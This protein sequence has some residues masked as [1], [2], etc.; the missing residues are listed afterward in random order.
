MGLASLSSGRCRRRWRAKRIPNRLDNR[1]RFVKHLVVPE[2]Q[3][4][5]PRCIEAS[6]ARVIVLDLLRV[7][8]AV[9]FDHQ[10]GLETDEVENVI[11][12]RMLPAESETS[13]L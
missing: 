13:H 2:S 12:E 6:C 3:Y 7:L 4:V 5:E 8:P 11:L 10:H 1:F 9:D